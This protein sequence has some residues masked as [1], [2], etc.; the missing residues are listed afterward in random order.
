M[1][2]VRGELGFVPLCPQLGAEV[3]G[4]TAH[5]TWSPRIAAAVRAAL[6]AYH[7]LLF[8][9][10]IMLDDE[11]ISFA[12]QF[13]EPFT[14]TIPPGHVR[15][16]A[17]DGSQSDLAE[18]GWHADHTRYPGQ[19]P[20]E[21]FLH[22]E[23]A[24]Q[25][26]GET[27]FVSTYEIFDEFPAERQARL[28]DVRVLFDPH[29][30]AKTAAVS[31]PRDIRETTLSHVG[32]RVGATVHPLVLTH[33]ESGRRSLFAPP[34]N[35]ARLLR[36]SPAAGAA[37]LR[38]IERR[39]LRPERIY[40]HRWQAGD[41]IVWDQLGTWHR[42]EPLTGSAARHLRNF[43]TVMDAVHYELPAEPGEA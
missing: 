31:D 9:G 33:P 40:T 7:V 27:S 23:L 43:R 22:A 10:R 36:I 6:H 5:G 11:L 30:Y 26:G 38:D 13:G 1:R 34:V 3:L 17:A 2:T 4:I 25:S 42:R 18:L 39:T 19:L 28:A 41:L 16:F 37:L 8:R 12:R 21:G 14:G 29:P 35:T 20:K 32:D 24:P 15:N